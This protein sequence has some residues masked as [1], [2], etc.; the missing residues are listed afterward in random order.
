MKTYSQYCPVAHALDLVG[1]RWSLLIVRELLKGPQR[2]TDLAAALPGCGTNILADRLEKLDGGGLVVRKKLPPPAASTVYELTDYGRG[3]DEALNALGRW[4]ARS[5]GPPSAADDL[6]PGWSVN[7]VRCAY[8]PAAARELDATYELRF[9]GGE[10]TTVVVRD[11]R[12]E[13]WAGP[14]ETP[15]LVLE[16]DPPTMFELVAKT[17]SPEDALA[18]GRVRI[19]GDT[20]DFVRLVSLFSFEPAAAGAPAVA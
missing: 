13:S 1:E 15:D 6:R 17:V 18:E 10:V 8:D 5:L 19:E 2:Y 4:G 9:G 7:A 3:L 11:G 14:A 16:T 20:D 12:L